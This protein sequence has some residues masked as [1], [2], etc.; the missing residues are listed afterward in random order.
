MRSYPDLVR[1]CTVIWKHKV[2]QTLSSPSCLLSVLYHSNRNPKLGN[3]LIITFIL[4]Y[5]IEIIFNHG[6]MLGSR[7]DHS[8]VRFCWILYLFFSCMCTCTFLLLLAFSIYL[9]C[10]S[11]VHLPA[12]CLSTC[13][14]VYVIFLSIYHLPLIHILTYHILLLTSLSI[15][16]LSMY[17]LSSFCLY[18]S[19]SLICLCNLLSVYHLSTHHSIINQ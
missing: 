1:C 18:L 15:I 5:F 4:L 3:R 6:S 10:F 16:Y 19:I 14:C 2:K 8:E 13:Q 11:S 12:T 17:H 9:S 7:I